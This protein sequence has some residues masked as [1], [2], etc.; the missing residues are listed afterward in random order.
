MQKCTGLA[1]QPGHLDDR[2]VGERTAQ[3]NRIKG[4]LFGQGPYGDVTG[5][6]TVDVQD[7]V[8]V[9]TAWGPCEEIAVA[10]L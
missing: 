2:L 4:L 7:L 10:I 6:G 8:A 5:D 1:V 3:I 9:I